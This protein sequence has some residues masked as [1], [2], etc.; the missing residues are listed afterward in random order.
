DYWWG[1]P[2]F[3][4]RRRDWQR[5]GGCNERLRIASDSDLLCWL[6][7]QGAMAYFAEPHYYR[8]QHGT[9]V[10]NRLIAMYVEALRVQTRYLLR[11][12]WL[13]QVE[14]LSW[15]LRHHFRLAASLAA[16]AGYYRD[17]LRCHVLGRRVWG[18]DAS[19]VR[20]I[21]RLLRNASRQDP[22]ASY[23]NLLKRH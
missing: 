9:N 12:P 11:Q 17:A 5:M 15:E 18:W 23:D 19:D 1:Y 8:R 2:G 10:C 22:E 21:A 13:L 3:L 16:E 20:A 6:C 4:F 14:G 7:T